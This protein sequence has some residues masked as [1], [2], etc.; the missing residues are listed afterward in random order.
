MV[1]KD[2]LRAEAHFYDCWNGKDLDSPDHQSHMAFQ[3]DGE[4]P[5][6]HPVKVPQIQ[7]EFGFKTSEYPFEDL[8]LSNGDKTGCSK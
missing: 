5:S 3:V 6:T 2:F 8:V 1:A 4:C 7:L